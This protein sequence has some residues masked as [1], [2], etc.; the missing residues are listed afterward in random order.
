MCYIENK[1]IFR[2]YVSNKHGKLF[3]KYLTKNNRQYDFFNFDS[4][5]INL[6]QLY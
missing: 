1:S 4:I 2:F 6:R 5:W 3:N